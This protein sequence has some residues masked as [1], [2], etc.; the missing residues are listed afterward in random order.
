[1]PVERIIEEAMAVC[2]VT[3]KDIPEEGPFDYRNENSNRYFQS[4]GFAHFHCP[5]E[6]H[7]HSGNSWGVLDLKTQTICYRYEQYCQKCGRAAKPDFTEHA[8]RTMAEIAVKSYLTKAGRIDYAQ[9]SSKKYK[10]LKH[11]CWD[12]K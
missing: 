2:L 12:G 5:N 3:A 10:K 8:L 11:S 4:R 9:K 7:W 1:M 6:H